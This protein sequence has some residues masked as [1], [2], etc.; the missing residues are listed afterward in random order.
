[1]CRPHRA[2]HSQRTRQDRNRLYVSDYDQP[3][4]KLAEI[5]ELLVVEAPAISSGTEGRREF[6][7]I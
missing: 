7:H 3:T 6:Q 2:V 5:I 4:N 1:M